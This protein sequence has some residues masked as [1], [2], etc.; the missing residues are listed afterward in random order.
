MLGCSVDPSTPTSLGAAVQDGF[1]ATPPA[2]PVSTRR[3]LAGALAVV[4]A[5]VRAAGAVGQ[6]GNA[7]VLE[8]R[9]R[10]GESAGGVEGKDGGGGELHCADVFGG[11]SWSL[12]LCLSAPLYNPHILN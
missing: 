6:V 9:L 10:Q 11:L 12:E 3:L 4:I 8:D 7:S 1:R 2:F 5:D